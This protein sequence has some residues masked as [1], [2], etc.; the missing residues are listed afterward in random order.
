MSVGD[1]S[2]GYQILDFEAW[3]GRTFQ[4]E[5]FVS[6]RSAARQARSGPSTSVAAMPK[7]GSE[8]LDHIETGAEK[9]T[10]RDDMVAGLELADQGP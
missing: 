1:G 4:E 3:I 6:G 7:R 2:N 5:G 9:G 8:L 10:R